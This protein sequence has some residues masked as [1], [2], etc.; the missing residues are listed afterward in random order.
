MLSPS[1][2]KAVC[3]VCVCVCGREMEKTVGQMCGVPV[4]GELLKSSWSQTLFHIKSNWNEL[5]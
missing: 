2:F 3:C 4:G 5:K 1:H